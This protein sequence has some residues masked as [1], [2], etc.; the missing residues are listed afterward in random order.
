MRYTLHAERSTDTIWTTGW[1]RREDSRPAPKLAYISTTRRHLAPLS[2]SPGPTATLPER[3]TQS[4]LDGQLKSSR[5]DS[6]NE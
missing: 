6:E 1:R 4:S 3:Q 5:L 2:P